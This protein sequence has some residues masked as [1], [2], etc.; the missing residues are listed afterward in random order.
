MTLVPSM[1]R[2]ESASLDMGERRPFSGRSRADLAWLAVSAALH[3]AL[4]AAVLLAGARSLP[5]PAEPLALETEI[6]SS[7][8][9]AAL[10]AAPSPAVSSPSAEALPRT[11]RASAPSRARP[12]KPADPPDM[13]HPSRMLSE[14]AL[15]NPR[16]RGLRRE[17]EHLGDEDRLAQLCDLEAMEQIHAWRQDF[18]PDRLVDYALD[19]TKTEGAVLIADGGAFRSQHTWYEVSYRCELD[20]ARRKI[21]A[22]AFRVGDAIPREQWVAYN[23]PAT[24]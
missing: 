21:V 15:G 11:G 10:R 7:R 17:L 22:F 18:R 6:I 19:D 8:D 16:S 23:L 3:L 13:V 5:A 4:L 9:F 14:Q 24:H 12:A 2:A 20:E 1:P